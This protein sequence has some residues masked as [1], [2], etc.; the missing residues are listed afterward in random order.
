MSR[1]EKNY[2]HNLQLATSAIDVVQAVPDA[3]TSVISKLSF[4]NSSSTT[5]RLVTI[6]AVEDGG[7]ADTGNTVARR[8]IAPLTTWNVIEVINER[9]SKGMKLQATQDAGTDVN[10]NCS[11]ADFTQ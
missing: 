4:Y 2:A 11:G 6:H 8:S 10:A 7:T 1:I 3:V 9:L 5:A